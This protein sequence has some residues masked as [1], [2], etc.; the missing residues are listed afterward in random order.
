MPQNH[1]H[2]SKMVTQVVGAPVKD[3]PVV[4]RQFKQLPFERRRVS[5]NGPQLITVGF[6]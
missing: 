1:V 5:K 6:Q 3:H 2:G 4:S